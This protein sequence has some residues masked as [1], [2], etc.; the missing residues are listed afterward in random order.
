VRKNGGML[1]YDAVGLM[2]VVTVVTVSV[3]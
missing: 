3:V 1:V 2:C